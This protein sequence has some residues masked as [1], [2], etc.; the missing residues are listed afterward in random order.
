MYC[1]TA[2]DHILI[3]GLG[4]WKYKEND[5]AKFCLVLVSKKKKPSVMV[6]YFISFISVKGLILNIIYNTQHY[7]KES[8]KTLEKVNFAL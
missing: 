1:F 4:L 6:I 2:S 7:V 8:F 5:L 3:H